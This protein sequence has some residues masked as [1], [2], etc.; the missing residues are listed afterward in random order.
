MMEALRWFFLILAGFGL[1]SLLAGLYK[2]VTVL[3][4]LDRMNR[5]KVIKIY[6]ALT[7]FALSTCYLLKFL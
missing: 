7:L 6:G 1:V 5:S 2:P 3:W 4:F